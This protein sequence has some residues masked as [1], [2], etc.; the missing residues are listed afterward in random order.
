MLTPVAPA[1]PDVLQDLL[2]QSCLSLATVYAAAHTTL[3]KTQL[4][5]ISHALVSRIRRSCDTLHGTLDI[6][7]T[8]RINIWERQNNARITHEDFLDARNLR[9][10]QRFYIYC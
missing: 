1:S 2:L 9:V 6:N 3:M 4:I 7:C 10:N 8:M 5:I